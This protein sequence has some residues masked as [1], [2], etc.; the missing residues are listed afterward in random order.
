MNVHFSSARHNWTTPRAVYQT[1]FAEF[2][3]TCD[4][5]PSLPSADGLNSEWGE[6]CFVNPPYGRQIGK[7]VAKAHEQA[8]KGK[9]VVLLIPSRTD[10]RWWHEHCMAADEI[11]FIPGR[12]HFDEAPNPAPFP[13]AIVIFRPRGQGKD[14]HEQ[15]PTEIPRRDAAEE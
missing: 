12:L 6:R 4:P 3:F 8:N 7:W 10:T 9:L 13:S 11:R 15:A 2:R 14:C 5:C 1:L